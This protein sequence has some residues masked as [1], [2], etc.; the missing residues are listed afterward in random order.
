M[1]SIQVLVVDDD[2]GID[3]ALKTAAACMT[4]D[5]PVPFE[6]LKARGAEHALTQSVMENPDLCLILVGDDFTAAHAILAGLKEAGLNVPVTV[7]APPAEMPREA[8]LIERGAR[9][10]I[11]R[12]ASLGSVLHY[13]VRN[14]SAL[15]AA[16]DRLR[17]DRE[18]LLSQILDLRD[19]RERAEEQSIR[20]LEMVEELALA[21]ERLERLDQEKN[22]LFSI[23]AHDLRS[24]FTALL[25]YTAMI[26]D[27]SDKLD[28]EKI[29]HFARRAH[30]SGANIFKLLENLLEWVQL[31][32]NRTEYAP[33]QEKL[34]DIAARTFEIL[35]PVAQEKG[36][37][38]ECRLNGESA[39]VDPNMTAAV[40]RNLVNNAIK[41][42]P[43]G[44]IS[45][46]AETLPEHIAVSVRDN[47]I[48]MPPDVA[49]K[50]F[51]IAGN[52]STKGTNG[53]AGTGL[54]IILCKELVERGGGE[55]RVVSE[56]GRG[57]TF[58]FTVPR[59]PTTTPH[60][61]MSRPPSAQIR[62][63]QGDAG[64]VF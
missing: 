50:I 7:I 36:L 21:K 47:G 30:D 15:K 3:A 11:R 59:S 63:P 1:N 4:A 25:G 34:K 19:G 14:T 5:T 56:E 26:A 18:R 29:S 52:V 32:M 23:I 6:T 40:I 42:T 62:H 51:S 16:E 2:G 38:L 28:P 8:S 57:S 39:F 43:A 46:F 12:D 61:D 27:M 48:G 41:F 54:G 64:P 9:G 60:A 37:V 49:R 22:K 33:S 31:Q 55:L 17:A 44:K 58:T 13:I 10:V 45:V 20:Y 53:E 35:E 24:P